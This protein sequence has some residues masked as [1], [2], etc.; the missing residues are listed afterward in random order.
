MTTLNPLPLVAILR[1][2][3]PDDVLTHIEALYRTGFTMIEIPLNSPDWQVSITLAVKHYGTRVRI[4]AGTVT[5]ANQ[6]TILKH[7][8]CEFILTPNTDPCVIEAATAAGM[9][10]C[11]GCQ[12]ASEAFTALKHGATM[13][14]IFPAGD[15]GP[16]YIRSLKAILPP[17]TRLYAVGG[18]TPTNLADYLRAGCEGAGL[19]SDLYRVKQSP[20]ETAEKAQRFLEAW[21]CYAS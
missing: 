10:T 17:E 2:I 12:T 1:G 3:T 14:K 18:I 6:V 21:R 8:G 15:I 19:G 5:A 13:L 9:T 4:G 11:I 20:E 7:A 16:G